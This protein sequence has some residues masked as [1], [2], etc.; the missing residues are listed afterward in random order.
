MMSGKNY[1]GAGKI[2]EVQQNLMMSLSLYDEW[3]KLCRRG[4]NTLSPAKF[5]DVSEFV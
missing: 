3:E 4:E 2:H 1:A 5:D